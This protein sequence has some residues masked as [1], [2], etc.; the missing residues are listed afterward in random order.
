M[1]NKKTNLEWALY[2][3]SLGLS[4]IPTGKDKK[5][6]LNWKPYQDR[7]ATV[8]EIKGWWAIWP[9]ANPALVTGKVSGVVALDLDK[10]HN[11][12]SK[13]FTIPPT[14]C[15]KSGN[16]GEHFFF[17]Y[18]TDVS[19]KSGSAISGDGVDCRA[20]GGYILLAPSVNENGGTYE[21]TVPFE[22]R[23]DLA[24]MPE[25]FKKI[26]TNSNEDKK[27]LSGKDGVA[28]GSRSDTAA[29]MAGKIIS[30]TAPEL[31]ESLGWEQ[32]M[33]WN[34][35]NT[36][37]LLEKELRAT[38]ESIKKAHAGD[39]REASRASQANLLLETIINRKDM[40]LFH[41][42]QGNG[43]VSLEIDGHQVIMSCSG[44]AIKRWL[45]SEIYRTQKKAP[46]GEA[47]KSILSVLE[48]KA[49]YEG[50]EI[51]LKDRAAWYEDELWYDLT[52]ENWQAVKIN[53]EGWEVVDKPPILFKR[54]NH[55]KSQAMPVKGGDVK[56]F[57]NYVN[58][59]DQENRLLFLV[60]LVSCFISDF[61]HVMLVV[62]GAQ[63]SSKSTLSKLARLVVDP[64][65]VDVVA[66]PSS[67]RELIQVLAHHYF[68]F[69]DNVSFISEELS[70]TL[71]K[72]VTGSGF[73]KRELY[74]NDEDIIYNIKRCIGMNG[75]NLVATRPD[76]LERGLLLELERIEEAD[77]KPER[78]L[79][80]SFEKDLPLILGGVFDV[81]VKTLQ[82]KPT[83][84][85][86]SL[87]RM[88]DWSFWGCAIAEALGYTKEEFLSAY[89]SNITHQ[90]EMLL[91]DNIVAMAVFAFMEDRESWIGT[92]TDFLKRLTEH[93]SFADIDTREKYWPKGA[94]A[95]SRKLNELSTPLK[96]MGISIVTNTSGAERSIHLQ[97]VREKVALQKDSS[98]EV[99]QLLPADGSDDTDDVSAISQGQVGSG[100]VSALF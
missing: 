30:S 96:Q 3:L 12:T 18:P 10:K 98:T 27:W 64:S 4:I 53:K 78:E 97:K 17:K 73:S 61:A 9:D 94:Q 83:L 8:G 65:L 38:W 31:Q 70:D 74:E 44:K 45:S 76:L 72:A 71:C 25:W 54:Y 87:P 26:T 37:P 41:D 79:C 15:A 24:E 57:L 63:G 58:I 20:D 91:N 80:E 47:V 51:E 16:G 81:L 55:Q 69:F 48:G 22:T 56:L 35:K 34:Q 68:L 46:G 29:S 6:L 99:V 43:H 13:E 14:A 33:I 77:R 75:I 42:E 49:C 50:P 1:Q 90:T 52:N 84:E 85:V 59:K 7:C 2:Y 86:D 32:L 36:K 5:P 39:V 21:W 88:A 92:P 95:L 66:L 23:D 67:Q 40:V 100:E 28:E 62:F 89:R 11:R 60:F 82:I 19:V 93:A